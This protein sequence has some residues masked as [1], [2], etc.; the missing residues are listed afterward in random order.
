MITLNQSYTYEE[1]LRNLQESGTQYPEST[2]YKKVGESHDERPIPMLRV[3]LGLDTLILTSGIHGKESINPVLLTRMAQEYCQAYQDNS[4][5]GNYQVREL[6]NHCSI[7]FLPIVNPDGYVIATESFSAI[8]NPILRQACKMRGVDWPY[9]KYNARAVDINRNFPCKSYIQQQFGEYPAS[10]QETQTLIRVFEQWDTIGYLDFHSRGRIIYYYRQAMPFSYNQ[11]NHKLAR[12]MQKLSNYSLGKQ[13]E[14][15]LSRLN[16]GSPVNY[17][18][19]LLHKPAITVE[20][21]EEN[22]DFPMDPSCQ[23]RTYEEIRML[24]LEIIAQSAG[25][26]EPLKNPQKIR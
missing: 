17:Y 18:S 15:Y 16:G 21:V 12:Y 1:L 19:E 4:Y 8:R 23:E 25:N 7:C 26:S 3:G 14:E 11:R 5:M 10:E 6:L 22:A 9:W 2:I 20:T 24:P 13:E